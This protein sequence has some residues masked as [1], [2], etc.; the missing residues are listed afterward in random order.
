MIAIFISALSGCANTTTTPTPKSMDLDYKTVKNSYTVGEAFASGVKVKVTY[1]DN[2][3]EEVTVTESMVE[4]F[5]TATL[6]EGLT[7]TIKYKGLTTTMVYDVVESG[8]I[9]NNVTV[10]LAYSLQGAVA[11][12]ILDLVGIDNNI[13]V[14]GFSAEVYCSGLQ[15]G[16]VAINAPSGYEIVKKVYEEAVLLVFYPKDG[17]TKLKNGDIKVTLTATM[18]A[19]SGLIKARNC[20]IT[21]KYSDIPLASNT[22]QIVKRE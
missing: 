14:Y 8:S 2:Q 22:M 18:V 5:S 7:C 21:N 13:D 6:G 16:N 15:L 4:G 11:T 9:A 12:V 3:V 17:N 10:N 1:S 20:K 19:E